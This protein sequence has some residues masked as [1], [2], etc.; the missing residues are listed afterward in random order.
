MA[1]YGRKNGCPVT[2]RKAS[3]YAAANAAM[4]RAES[5]NQRRSRNRRETTS[6][7]ASIAGK[8]ESARTPFT[9][10]AHNAAVENPIPHQRD[11]GS[12]RRQSK[13]PRNAL[14]QA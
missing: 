8:K 2:R 7:K 3:S 11:R 13:P 1:T 14:A 4:S 5:T 6:Q 10:K 9:A 12:S